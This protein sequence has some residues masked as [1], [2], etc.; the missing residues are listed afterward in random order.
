M[1]FLKCNPIREY[2]DVHDMKRGVMICTVIGIIFIYTY[3]ELGVIISL[4]SIFSLPLP[5]GSWRHVLILRMILF[6]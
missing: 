6:L 4:L 5:T 3:T 2:D 1:G